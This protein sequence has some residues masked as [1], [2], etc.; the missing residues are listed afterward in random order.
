MNNDTS[1]NDQ[2][3]N[4]VYDDN[5]R[6]HCWQLY[7]NNFIYSKII[8]FNLNNILDIG[9]GRGFVTDYLYK[10]NIIIQGIELGNTTPIK[11][12]TVKIDFGKDFLELDKNLNI[13][14]VTLF[15]V[16]E[17]IAQPIDFIKSIIDH[18]KNLQ[19]VFIS[20][21]ANNELW[22]NWDEINGHYKRYSLN[23]LDEHQEF[24]NCKI[25]E[26]QYF[27]HSLYY[28]MYLHKIFIKKRKTVF[29][30][31]NN[32]NLLSKFIHKIVYHLFRLEKIFFSKK[33]KGSSIIYILKINKS[34]V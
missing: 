10:K 20:V 24:L 2:L 4:D 12:A 9:C 8:E 29:S 19:Y 18:F 30:S 33:N 7:R 26:K 28:L 17:H 31:N 11:N 22:T 25:I 27:F 23:D 14:T 15:D 1:F 16:I 5:F 34:A 13:N 3:F 6:F 21:P 32:P